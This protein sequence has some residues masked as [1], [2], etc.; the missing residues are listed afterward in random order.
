MPK[1]ENTD[2]TNITVLSCREIEKDD[3]HECYKITVEDENNNLYTWKDTVTACGCD[4]TTLSDAIKAHVLTLD[5][6]EVVVTPV[7]THN[8]RNDVIGSTLS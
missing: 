5:K 3:V 7:I 4:E 2:L 1:F 8:D 6:T